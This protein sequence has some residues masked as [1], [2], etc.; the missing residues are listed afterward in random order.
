[1]KM[2]VLGQRYP[3]PVSRVPNGLPGL[4]GGPSRGE[5]SRYI[6]YVL[7]QQA[8]RVLSQERT[9]PVLTEGVLTNIDVYLGVLDDFLEQL[10]AA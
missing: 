4:A 7:R 9:A 2:P 3:S 6:N 10:C 5:I 8:K 1:M